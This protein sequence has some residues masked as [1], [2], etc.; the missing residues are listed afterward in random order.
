[1]LASSFS[2]SA[3][4]RD[5]GRSWKP[6]GV[7][8]VANAKPQAVEVVLIAE[9]RDDVAQAVVPAMAAAALELGDAGR[10]VEFVVRHQDFFRLDAE[11]IGK[12]ATAW[13][14]RFM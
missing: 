8:R 10:Q 5:P 7:A 11:E 2:C 9:L 4:A 14:L 3:R 13:P 12:A 6:A 1:M